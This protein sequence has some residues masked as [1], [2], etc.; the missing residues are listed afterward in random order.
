MLAEEE[1]EEDA[2][3]MLRQCQDTVDYISLEELSEV[4]PEE[5][6]FLRLPEDG[7]RRGPR[8]RCLVRSSIRSYA[9][10]TEQ[11]LGLVDE[12]GSKARLVVPTY[13][14]GVDLEDRDLQ[15]LLR[16]LEAPPP[17]P[18]R[19]L[20][21][22]INAVAE[23]PASRVRGQRHDTAVHVFELREARLEREL[24][25]VLDE[26]MMASSGTKHCPAGHRLTCSLSTAPFSLIVCDGCEQT[27]VDIRRHRCS[28]N[29]D[30]DLCEAC[31][32]S[33]ARGGTVDR[34]GC[35]KEKMQSFWKQNS[36]F[37]LPP[38]PPYADDG[39]RQ[40]SSA[41]TKWNGFS[42]DVEAML[43]LRQVFL[44]HLQAEPS[45]LVPLRSQFWPGCFELVL[46]VEAFSRRWQ[47]QTAKRHCNAS[48]A[49]VQLLRESLPQRWASLLADVDLEELLDLSMRAL[50][51]GI[52]LSLRWS[53]T[54]RRRW[55]P[56]A[57]Q[58]ALSCLG[59]LPWGRLPWKTLL[60]AAILA[61]TSLL[62]ITR[63]R[64][65]R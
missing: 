11:C 61:Q 10:T 9:Q 51:G 27:L 48:V 64:I 20:V 21:L 47:L 62:T 26:A 28:Q 37:H 42:L 22:H 44:D 38:V 39:R 30:F 35:L 17:N 53:S 18:S 40:L 49:A 14:P 31:F 59:R 33:S 34:A 58:A 1:K 56:W 6:V 63:D 3:A 36:A 43:S 13:L 60:V 45:Y 25:G 50:E 7:L 41:L 15:F 54:R 8:Y 52:P 2:A 65:L 29:C 46:N 57:A 32:S 12:T 4:P 23:A 5:L 55:L 16:C 24:W 19:A